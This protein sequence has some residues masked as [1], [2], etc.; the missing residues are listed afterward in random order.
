MVSFAFI[1]LKTWRPSWMFFTS[2]HWKQFFELN[3]FPPVQSSDFEIPGPSAGRAFLS[4]SKA[5]TACLRVVCEPRLNS[6]NFFSY[7]DF[8]SFLLRKQYWPLSR[9]E[10][11]KQFVHP[12]QCERKA[13]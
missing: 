6:S 7:S 1:T 11:R 12:R 8:E 13:E 9:S 5:S 2:K 3:M 4:F 10:H